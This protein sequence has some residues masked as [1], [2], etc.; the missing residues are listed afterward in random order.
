VRSDLRTFAP[1]L[2]CAATIAAAL[3]HVAIDIVGD[4]ALPH[5]TY[6]YIAHGSRELVTV[7]AAL[8][9]AAI[10]FRGLHICC[11]LATANRGRVSAPELGKW[12]GVLFVFLVLS[13]AAILVPA[14]EV[15][16]GR[17]AGTPVTELD[18][19]FGG[20]LLLG[21]STT[22]GCAAAVAGIILGFARWLISHRDSI[23]TM[24]VSLLVRV[25]PDSRP[26]AQTLRRCTAQPR[27]RRTAPALQLSKRGPPSVAFS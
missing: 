10:A 3:S 16:D 24:I 27:R 20:S 8:A 17:L 4:Y 19:A 12:R 25:H 23:A 21:L 14:M 9:A 7:I 22:I 26:R 6:D 11:D 2:L 13:L 1:L 5:D 15:L 18:D